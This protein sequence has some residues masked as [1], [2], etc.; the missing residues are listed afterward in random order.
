M[1]HAV[2]AAGS[3]FTSVF[4]YILPGFNEK[5]PIQY[6]YSCKPIRAI[7]GICDNGDAV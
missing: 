5:Y 7:R 2:E 1:R 4:Y 3:S 6:S